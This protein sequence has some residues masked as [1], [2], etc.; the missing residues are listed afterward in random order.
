MDSKWGF[1]PIMNPPEVLIF[2][3]RRH[4]YDRL[5][6]RRTNGDFAGKRLLY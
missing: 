1:A 5:R 6:A 3:R 4:F 2:I